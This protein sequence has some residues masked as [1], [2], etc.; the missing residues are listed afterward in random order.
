[1]LNERVTG[2]VVLNVYDYSGVNCCLDPLGLG[3]YHS[4]EEEEGLCAIV[5]L[6]VSMP[7]RRQ[8]DMGPI[9][10]PR[11]EFT[12]VLREMGK[13]FPVRDYNLFNN[14]CNHFCRSFVKRLTS[15]E[16]PGYLTRATELC[17]CLNWCLPANLTNG[18]WALEQQLKDR[19]DYQEFTDEA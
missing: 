9:S 13:E 15:R 19:R 12:R 14:N 8:L 17:G 5:P 3:L 11:A 16:V 7:I 1:M 6:S 4:G 18:Q 2:R 10:M